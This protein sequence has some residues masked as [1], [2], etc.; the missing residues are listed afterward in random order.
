MKGK[1]ENLCNKVTLRINL[2]N[3]LNEQL[4]TCSAFF[5]P[6]TC[7]IDNESKYI[8]ENKPTQ[9]KAHLPSRD[10]GVLVPSPQWM[11]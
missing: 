2:Y 4:S 9:L 8:I 10:T 3:H 5:V 1:E 7:A 11:T 6:L